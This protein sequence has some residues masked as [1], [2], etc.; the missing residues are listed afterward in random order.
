MAEH[1]A[2]WYAGPAHG[3]V[4]PRGLALLDVSVAPAVADTVWHSA[5]GDL[6]EFLDALRDATGGSLMRLPA[7]AAAFPVEHGWK[8]AVHGGLRAHLL[9]PGAPTLV[10]H[11]GPTWVERQ[12]DQV[13]R[14]GL[15]LPTHA[16]RPGVVGR[17]VYAGVVPA[18]ALLCAP[19]DAHPAPAEPAED[20]TPPAQQDPPFM[21]PTRQTRPALATDSSGSGQSI[22]GSFAHLWADTMLG[23]E[24]STP[25]PHRPASGMPASDAPAPETPAANGPDPRPAL[26]G[27]HDGHTI[28]ARGLA[29]PLAAPPAA[30]EGLVQARLCPL[31]HA[32][33]SS[34][35][36]CVSC[37]ATL[38]EQSV[39]VPQPPLG[40]AVLPSGQAV[41]LSTPVIVGR[42]PRA[43]Q[44]SAGPLPQLVVLP[45]DHVS[46][47]HLRLVPEGWQVYV[48]DLHS[49]NGTYL[50]RPGERTIRLPE[51]PVQV[52]SGDI[53]DL[54]HGVQITLHDVP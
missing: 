41:E 35:S 21:A 49:T 44:V 7:F 32:N 14:L 51:R 50:R 5:P 46:G 48:I 8:V 30:A 15:A 10:E 31:G 47:N 1:T 19:V 40:R 23:A 18:G 43:N 3:L 22:P 26:S 45:Q 13:E 34:R 4:W 25:T 16:V 54:G 42:H 53:L 29:A 36:S 52:R 38:A 20:V 12:F 9:C 39:Q 28:L 11:N 6:T 24:A 37:G 33:P 2:S 17:P 27:D